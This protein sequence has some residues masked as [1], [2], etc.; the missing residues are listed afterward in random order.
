[1]AHFRIT[2]SV[3]DSQLATWLMSGWLCPRRTVPAAA[4]VLR[5]CS[6]STS[7]GLRAERR[8]QGLREGRGGQRSGRHAAHWQ[9]CGCKG[10]YM[11][12]IAGAHAP[13]SSPQTFQMNLMGMMMMSFICD[14]ASTMTLV[15]QWWFFVPFGKLGRVL[16]PL[17]VNHP[18]CPFIQMT[19]TQV[20]F[21]SCYNTVGH[22]RMYV[23]T[24]TS[25]PSLPLSRPW[26]GLSRRRR[27]RTS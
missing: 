5:S 25:P 11:L 15:V 23:M 9:G 17:P 2:A 13:H 10:S 4:Y 20:T 16:H 7:P 6:T 24:L 8:T 12:L 27:N 22:T 26:S 19:D 3:V 21:L 18:Q 14:D 1:M